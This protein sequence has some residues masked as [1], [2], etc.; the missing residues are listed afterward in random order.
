M[1]KA[2]K[3]ILNFQKEKEG[4]ITILVLIMGLAVILFT[5]TMVGY[6]FRDIGF[7]KFDE[8]KLR[9]LNFTE[10]G[11]SNMYLNID[12]YSKGLIPELP[13]SHYTR[14]VYSSVG[15]LDPE[16][17]FTVEYETYYLGGY[18]KIPG[19]IITSK[20]IDISSGATRTVR[21]NALYIAIYDFI[22]TGEIS[23]ATQNLSGQTNITGPFFVDGDLGPLTGNSSILGGP[24]F[25]RGDITI[26]GTSSIGE[27]GNP[28]ILFMGGDMYVHNGSSFDPIN[29]PHNVDVY[30]SEYYDTVIDITPYTIDSSYI[31]SVVDSGAL[32]IGSPSENRNLFIGDEIIKVDGEEIINGY[33]GLKFNNDGVLEI[34]GNIVV[35]GDIDIGKSTGPKYTIYYSG[36]GN[37]I[38][39]GDITVGSQVIPEYMTNFPSDDLMVLISQ[40]NIDLNLTNASGGSYNDPNAAVMA[41]ANNKIEITTNTFLR[42]GTV[43]S[44]LV[45]GINTK[46]HYEAG[47]REA[48]TA[49]VPGF[50]KKIKIQMNWQEIIAD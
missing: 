42:G 13:A 33:E 12:Q 31:K 21:V 30:V 29:P 14:L 35:Y 22:Y 25:V 49:G 44:S 43:S 10:S 4:N 3:K 27:Y 16:G 24:L 34:S 15:D 48:L 18:S 11:L 1:S 20:G 46:I 38:S 32:V 2:I 7:T 23:G 47:I 37:L 19:Y 6:I 41:I 8:G 26:D 40:N 17:S 45:L 50:G 39:T 28:I 36:N 5:T 9:A